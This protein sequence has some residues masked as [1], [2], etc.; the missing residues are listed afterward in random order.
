MVHNL[1]TWSHKNEA[2]PALQMEE[3]D[4]LPDVPVSSSIDL[5]RFR[6]PT[7]H[8]SLRRSWVRTIMLTQSY[9]FICIA[10]VP[11]TIEGLPP[12]YP[13]VVW[14][15]TKMGTHVTLR[16]QAVVFQIL[17]GDAN[18]TKFGQQ[19]ERIK[20]TKGDQNIATTRVPAFFC[21]APEDISNEHFP[22][23]QW[24]FQKGRELLSRQLHIPSR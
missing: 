18:M 8:A 10:P 4:E 11:M 3:L 15:I 24:T 16:L 1:H 2:S 17:I 22:A 19:G 9:V 21:L 5:D 14:Y 7:K 12:V 13:H 23:K 20:P 6:G